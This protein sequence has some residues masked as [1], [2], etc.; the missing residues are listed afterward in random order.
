MKFYDREAEL[1]ALEKACS[2]K[3]SEM[4]VDTIPYNQK[5]AHFQ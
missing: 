2:L 3:G 1:E 4:I 5:K